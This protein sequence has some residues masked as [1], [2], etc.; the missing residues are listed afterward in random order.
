MGV[1][2]NVLSK[3]KFINYYTIKFYHINNIYETV[4]NLWRYWN[5][6]LI[7]HRYFMQNRSINF[8]DILD[9]K[10]NLYNII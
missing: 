8:F 6:F 2:E 10:K 5:K 4:E 3:Y 1:L 7:F 9:I